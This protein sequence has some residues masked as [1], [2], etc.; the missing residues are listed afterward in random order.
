MDCVSIYK[1]LKL[2][3]NF[4]RAVSA[5]I[6][7]NRLTSAIV[8]LFSPDSRQLNISKY[9]CLVKTL[10]KGLPTGKTCAKIAGQY[11]PRL[12]CIP[13]RVIIPWKYKIVKFS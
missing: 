3:I 8:R 4:N 2:Y 6:C 7:R 11:R 9:N 5:Q 12:A 13:K 1:V 10:R